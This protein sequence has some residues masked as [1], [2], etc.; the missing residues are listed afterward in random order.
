MK[1]I[2]HAIDAHG[3]DDSA[4]IFSCMDGVIRAYPLRGFKNRYDGKDDEMLYEIFC[5]IK[6]FFEDNPG[7][8]LDG[9][10]KY[11]MKEVLNEVVLKKRI[12]HVSA[13]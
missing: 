7:H 3:G 13:N 8:Y 12:K 10:L 4:V 6:S 5:D 1:K 11:W 9:M 2:I